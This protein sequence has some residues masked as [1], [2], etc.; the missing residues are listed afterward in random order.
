M[1]QHNWLNN[2]SVWVDVASSSV[3]KSHAKFICW[4]AQFLFTSALKLD[5]VSPVV[6]NM[7]PTLTF[8][9]VEWKIDSLVIISCKGT[10]GNIFYNTYSKW[11]WEI[12]LNILK[13]ISNGLICY[14]F[15]FSN[16]S[17]PIISMDHRSWA[18]VYDFYLFQRLLADAVRV[19][20]TM[21]LLSLF[22][23]TLLTK[24]D[25][26]YFGCGPRHLSRSLVASRS[27]CLYLL[28]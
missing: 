1:P 9:K 19:I 14:I 3:R 11:G 5:V 6:A 27:V 28:T 7:D 21:S 20:L 8:W 13:L 4:P 25:S 10:T 15:V 26:I 17:L 2:I 24:E 22:Y 16:V 12:L 23:S 18:I